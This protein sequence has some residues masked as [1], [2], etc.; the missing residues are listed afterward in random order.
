[1]KQYD[2]EKMEL[3]TRDVVAR[4]IFS[5]IK[6]GRDTPRGGVRLDISHKAADYIK[7]R[8]PKMYSMILE[9]NNVD[10]TKAPVEVAPTTHY[11][12][13]GIRF[14][15]ETMKTSIENFFVAGECTMG[16]HGANRLGGNSL[17]ETMVFGKRVAEVI[18]STTRPVPPS[19]DLHEEVRSEFSVHEH[20]LHAPTIL[21]DIREKVRLLGGIVR[22]NQELLTLSVYLEETKTAL[23]EQGIQSMD[24]HFS[25]V[26]IGKR[27]QT[28]LDLAS[29]LAYGATERK[30]SR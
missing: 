3:S 4:A 24:S 21:Q 23:L 8:L 2:P 22:N 9:Y 29:L 19:P 25:T 28:V 15:P 1:M 17:M 13:G 30:E 5:E 12:M 20:G 18:L 11:T 14:D 16:V 6:A 26:V 27:I 7:D 10:I